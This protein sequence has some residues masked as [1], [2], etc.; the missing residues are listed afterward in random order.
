MTLNWG[1]RFRFAWVVLGC[2]AIL[3]GGGA[4]AGKGPAPSPQPVGPEATYLRPAPYDRL[5]VKVDRVE[6]VSV[7]PRW[8]ADLKAFLAA[9]CR[10]PRGIQMEQ[11][12]PI[13]L[14]AVKGYSPNQIA[15]MRIDGPPAGA[16]RT[17][18]L[19]VLFYDSRKLGHKR[20]DSP[21]VS[22]GDYPCAIYYDVA[23]ARKEQPYF[24]PNALR[25]EAGH[26]LGLC[27]NR[28]HGD[29]VHCSDKA[30]LMYWTFVLPRDWSHHPPVREEL[31]KDC[32]N[33]LR[34]AQADR[35][36]GRFFF[37]GPVLVRQE[38]SYWVLSYPGMVGLAFDRQH[39][40]DW[41]GLVHDYR[42][43]IRTKG[44]TADGGVYAVWQ[45]RAQS[46]DA[47]S[48][49][50]QALER[51]RKDPSPLVQDTAKEAQRQLRLE[52]KRKPAKLAASL[53]QEW[54][55]ASVSPGS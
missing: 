52:L 23:Y 4:A 18:Y 36:D 21:H 49:L 12:K 24:A 30:C 44:K 11:G 9:H 28:A 31:C 34:Q 8:L 17:A 51:A 33:D 19:Y 45:L 55:A 37:A 16:V 50:N 2:A 54:A 40:T 25:H 26:A 47:V 48:R 22:Y 35:P 43:W 27:K 41:R 46:R 39:A 38:K 53:T 20:P 10:K 13:P 1:R 14:K 3:V 29:G 5:Y 15:G 42:V 6:G 32:L 7:D